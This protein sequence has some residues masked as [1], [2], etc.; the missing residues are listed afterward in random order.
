LRRI[1]IVLAQWCPHCVPLS[2][3]RVQLMAA[4]LGV[5]LRVLDID[6]PDLVNE[7]DL[8]VKQHGDLVEDYLVPQVFFEHDDGS[9]SHVFTGFSEGVQVTSAR[10]DDF[11]RSK[12]YAS[13]RKPPPLGIIPNSSLCMKGRGVPPSFDRA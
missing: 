11:F 12:Y 8:L 4:E 9:K 7:A 5:G 2:L 1:L 10:W 13:L 3:E 6:R